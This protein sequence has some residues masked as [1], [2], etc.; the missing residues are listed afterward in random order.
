MFQV[1]KYHY[2]QRQRSG[3]PEADICIS[4]AVPIHQRHFNRTVYVDISVSLSHH[5]MLSIQILSYSSANMDYATAHLSKTS[6]I[7]KEK[8]FKK[9]TKM[10][11]RQ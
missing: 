6:T 7:K 4:S 10:G 1:Y 5:I 3:S 9:K 11:K 2:L 8:I